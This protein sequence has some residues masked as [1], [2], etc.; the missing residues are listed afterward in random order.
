MFLSMRT[1]LFNLKQ[2]SVS[3]GSEGTGGGAG[4]GKALDRGPEARPE[5]D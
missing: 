5:Q 4:Q 1:F 2:C 3:G